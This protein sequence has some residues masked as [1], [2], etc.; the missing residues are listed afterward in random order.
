MAAR[1][2][3]ITGLPGSGKSTIAREFCEIGK[4]AGVPFFH[5]EMDAI[6]EMIFPVPQYSDSE[7]DKAYAVLA[8]MAEFLV[9]NGINVA[10]DATAH[11]K[12]YRTSAMER[13]EGLTEVFID[14]SVGTC[15]EREARRGDAG[16]MTDMYEKA[17]VRKNTGR[18]FPGL[19]EVIGVDVPYE[20]N[21]D[22][23]MVISSETYGPTEKAREIWNY[24]NGE[25]G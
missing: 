17:L 11:K 2:I 13:I 23:E 1:C 22:A 14:V 6:R 19:G 20:K 12:K 10:I 7:R 21:P 5:L 18:E 4:A 24:L 3:W 25:M 9:M 15:M 8:F 16:I